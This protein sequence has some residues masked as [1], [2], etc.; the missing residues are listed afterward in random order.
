MNY[1]PRLP[2]RNHNV[3]EV[4]P[5]RELAVLLGGLLA[6]IIFAYLLLGLGADLLVSR[7]SPATEQKL[8]ALLSSH[9][10]KPSQ[11][12]P[13]EIELQAIIN[14]MEQSGCVDLPYPVSVHIVDSKTVN[15]M[16]LPGGYI[17]VFSGLLKIVRSENELAFVLGHELGHFKHR[18][19]LRGLGRGLVFAFLATLTG[20][21]ESAVSQLAI[22]AV[23]VTESGFSRSQEAAADAYSLH[24]L[25]CV[26]GHVGGATDFFIHMPKK[27][28]PGHIGHYFAS[29]PENKKRIQALIALQRKKG[30]R[31]GPLIPLPALKK[32]A[33]KEKKSY[34]SPR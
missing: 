26:Y 34:P 23:Q 9:Y 2:G 12:T 21:S 1:T 32:R 11:P 15:A 7:I 8:A 14:K 17:T 24:I 27:L 30:Y 33:V 25:N 4:S 6:I 31:S 20:T 28:D 3:T 18:D 13:R 19:H 29:H 5:L 16:A 10:G 22:K